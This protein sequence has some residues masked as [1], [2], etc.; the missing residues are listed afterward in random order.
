MA[1]DLHGFWDA[2]VETLGS[3]VRG[4]ADVRE[5]YN[6]T[7]PLYYAGLDPSKINFGLA[8]Y[9][10]GYTLSGPSKPGKCTNSAGVLSL[11]EI[12]NLIKEKNIKPRLN[13]ESMMKELVWDDQW[14]GYD[15]EETHELK[16]KFANDLCFG[17]TMAWSVDFN[18]GTGDTDD[19]P[20]STDGRCGPDNGG[21]QD[22]DHYPKTMAMAV[23]ESGSP[24]PIYFFDPEDPDRPLPP[25]GSNPDDPDDPDDDEPEPM[26]GIAYD[27]YFELWEPWDITPLSEDEE[28]DAARD[29]LSTLSS[30]GL[31]EDFTTT[32]TT[33]TSRPTTTKNTDIP[34]PTGPDTPKPYC[35][36]EY[37]D[38]GR[39]L[40]FDGSEAE[41]VVEHLCASPPL[42][43]SNTFGYV[44]RSEST[45]LL[46]SVKWSEDQSGCKSK[47]EVPMGDW[48]IDS[49]AQMLL[50]CD[51]SDLNKAYGA[52]IVDRYDYGC[53]TWWISKESSGLMTVDSTSGQRNGTHTGIVVQLNGA[54]RDAIEAEIASLEPDFPHILETR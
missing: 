37:N 48:C 24:K 41:V 47:G 51:G 30:E 19:A 39:W 38:D 28:L 53:V 9:G 29:V 52:A 13:S 6:N 44:S 20:L 22:A 43:S 17:G 26:P 33:T 23:H 18:S 54:S 34:L 15:D 50:A 4:Q 27:G 12:K 25:P 35:F 5:I 2:D 3:L 10:R 49:F 32:S 7:L 40:S 46:A 8:W 36:R 21:T 42:T 45:G 11:T 14:I 16:R 31:F 1:Y